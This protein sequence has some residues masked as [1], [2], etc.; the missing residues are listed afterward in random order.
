MKTKTVYSFDPKTLSFVGAI[1]L[2]ESDLSPVDRDEGREVWVIPGN[3]VEVAPPEHVPAGKYAAAVAGA[4]EIRT[5]PVPV[6]VRE[7]QAA[8]AA[9]AARVASASEHAA[10][11]QASVQAHLDAQARAQRF[12]SIDEAATYTTS[13]VPKF[14]AQASALVTLRDATW[15]VVE[16]ILDDIAAGAIEP[17]K[18]SDIAPKLPVY[19]A[20]KVAADT[21]ALEDARA[22]AVAQAAADAR[23]L[24]EDQAA[25]D[26]EVQT[27]AAR[28]AEAAP[29]TVAR[30]SAKKKA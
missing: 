14:W 11:L 8:A 4:W 30:K 6:G 12:D 7:T 21:K 18:L 3:C 22:A 9:P 16:P 24:A 17:Q 19:D 25:R 27:N 5:V 26:A 2:D 20:I 1:V 23:Q 28:S 15:V 13:L 29:A 10:M